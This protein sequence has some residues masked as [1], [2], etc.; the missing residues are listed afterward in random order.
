MQESERAKIAAV[1]LYK[2]HI[3]DPT[4][5]DL[6]LRAIEVRMESAGPDISLHQCSG[7]RTQGGY[8]FFVD[9]LAAA[10]E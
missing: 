1:R 7:S 10:L 4:T 3:A 6:K 2:A 9:D 8:L 5:A